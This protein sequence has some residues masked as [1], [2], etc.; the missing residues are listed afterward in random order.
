MPSLTY[1]PTQLS[2]V[3]GDILIE[4]I[5]FGYVAAAQ[6]WS[7]GS[8]NAG[9]NLEISS[10]NNLPKLDRLQRGQRYYDG[11]GVA[12]VQM[13]ALWQKTVETIEE[14]FAKIIAQTNDQQI[15]LDMLVEV[16]NTAIGAA[17]QAQTVTDSV[18]LANSHTVPVNGI[19]TA[20][21]A[22]TI[23]IAPHQRYY[24][25]T[26]TVDVDGG[27]I[28]GL[29]EG[30]FYRVYYNDTAREGGAVSYQASVGDVVQSGATHVVGGA[31]IPIAGS[32]PSSGVGTT[33]PGYIPDEDF[34]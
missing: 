31:T 17:Q 1:T 25:P 29:T 7:G 23:T 6:N 3:G 21:S 19:L 16:Q 2:W 20:S 24:S 4:P 26:N 14:A 15:T 28:S 10:A 33:P 9:P 27:L 12:T 30:S 34:R 32:P 13:Q 22:G 8:V 11:Q 5:R 18:E